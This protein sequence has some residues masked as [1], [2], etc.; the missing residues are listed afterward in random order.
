[1]AELADALGLGPSGATHGGSSPLA[2]TSRRARGAPGSPG[3]SG[4]DGGNGRR[5]GLKNRSPQGG[6]GS[7]PPLGTTIWYFGSIGFLYRRPHSERMLATIARARIAEIDATFAE[8]YPGVIAV[9]THLNA[10]R[11]RPH[12]RLNPLDVST[13]APGATSST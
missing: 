11:L 8:D 1:M 5:G 4:R 7:T 12:R 6:G 2:D 13:L 3:S 10:P 9:V